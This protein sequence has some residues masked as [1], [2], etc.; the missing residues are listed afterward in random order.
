MEKL[1]NQ[2]KTVPGTGESVR[3][4]RWVC[5]SLVNAI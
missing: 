5:Q 2:L 1:Y 3:N 4:W